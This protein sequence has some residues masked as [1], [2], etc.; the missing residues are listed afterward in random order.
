[1]DDYELRP[2][3]GL[4]SFVDIKELGEE[5]APHKVKQFDIAGISSRFPVKEGGENVTDVNPWVNISGNGKTL[6]E[7]PQGNAADSP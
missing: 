6:T 4:D 2:L 7:I 3:E 5:V 1:V